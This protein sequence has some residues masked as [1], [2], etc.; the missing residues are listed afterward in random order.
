MVYTKYMTMQRVQKIKL[1]RVIGIIVSLFAVPFALL[2]IVALQGTGSGHVW[3]VWYETFLLISIFANIV[4]VPFLL[5]GF[6]RRN[7]IPTLI[8]YVAVI[9]T[10]IF[11]ANTFIL[12][13]DIGVKG[14]PLITAMFMLPSL[15]YLI[16]RECEKRNG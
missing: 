14:N 1:L 5:I 16:T 10:I 7:I 8:L 9:H 6:I 3:Q 13:I 2:G 4:A 11:L 12:L 15:L